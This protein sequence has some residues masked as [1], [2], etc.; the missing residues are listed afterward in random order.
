MFNLRTEA[1]AA[2]YQR[3]LLKLME[4]YE[5]K[6]RPNW[7]AL[8]QQVYSAAA[9]VLEHNGHDFGPV[10]NQHRIVM[11]KRLTIDYRNILSFFGTFT[12]DQFQKQY[13]KSLQAPNIKGME[14]VYWGSVKEWSRESAL[15]KSRLIAGTTQQMIHGVIK[16]GMRDGKSNADLVKQLREGS[17]ELNKVRATRIVRTETHSA[18]SKAINQSVKSTGYS[19]DRIWR[20]TMDD[21]VRG[22]RIKD[23]YNHIRANG[24]KRGLEIPFDV[25]GDKLEYPGDPK[26]HP[27][28]T[29][30]CRCVITYHTVKADQVKPNIP[31]P[32]PRRKPSIVPEVIPEDDFVPAKTLD[33]VS[34][35]LR[36]NKLGYWDPNEKMASNTQL[37]ILN[38]ILKESDRIKNEFS[39]V[40]DFMQH[41]QGLLGNTLFNGQSF[42]S[43][44]SRVSG[45]YTLGGNTMTLAAR[46]PVI[47]ERTLTLGKWNVAKDNFIDTFN[48]EYA[49]HMFSNASHNEALKKGRIAFARSWSTLEKAEKLKVS[50]Y[51][52]TDI[53]EGWAESVCAWFHPGYTSSAK[54]LPKPIE[55]VMASIFPR[56]VA[57]VRKVKPVRAGKLPK[58]KPAK[59]KKPMPVIE[60]L[61]H[62]LLPGSKAIFYKDTVSPCTDYVRKNG[63]WYLMEK[64]VIDKAALKRLNGMALPPAWRNVIVATDPKKKIQA[65]GL[66]KAGRWQ[67]RYSA[68]HVEEAAKQKFARQQ[69]FTKAMPS[70]KEGIRKGIESN[71]AR[72]FVLE[73]ENRTAIRVGSMKD[74]K[75]KT[76]AYGLTTLQNE[77]LIV[78][79]NK[80]TLNFIAKE[81]LPVQY[82]I[83]DVTLAK[84]LAAR[85]EKTAV[86]E[87]LFPDVSAKKLNDY[88]KEVAGSKK[89]SVKDFRTYHGTRV[90]FE[91]L[92]QYGG[93]IWSAKE[94]AAITKNV[95]DKVSTFLANTPAMAKK[96]YIN[97]L[98]WDLIGG[99]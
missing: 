82:E 64:E 46:S 95:L 48:H 14:D 68:A 36:A 4:S 80:I 47:R 3:Y 56:K 90:A 77:H 81:G 42:I 24:Q 93:K 62:C 99:I 59:S 7:Y 89:F 1:E 25:S 85:K 31:G 16:R 87:K 11:V 96:S 43:N 76:K 39:T 5:R 92:K 84:W 75:A 71:D 74:F 52:A 29:I 15:S 41:G 28:N 44:G 18:A 53:G 78:E 63:K 67:Y 19:H 57:K 22:A 49:H 35:R 13:K 65:L 30:N 60:K 8:L 17:T 34:D 45:T 26:G 2:R 79:G 91:E 97:P 94:K 33:E 61:V 69:A 73:L 55:D 20:A 83:E 32:Q 72:A 6:L 21:R 27:G 70:I 38:G 54:K 9:T 12:F 98:V 50:Q 10:I 88:L 23:R 66:D 51:A 86:G 40:A 37:G 58:E